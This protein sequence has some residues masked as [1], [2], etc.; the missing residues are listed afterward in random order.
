MPWMRTGF[1]VVEAR[2]PVLSSTSRKLIV[3]PGL[4]TNQF[5][6][7][8]M[9]FDPEKDIVPLG[10]VA[11]IPNLLIVKNT[12]PFK[13]VAELIAY[14]KANPGKLNYGSSG[15]GATP[16]L[17]GEL[18]KRMAG[19]DI[20]VVHYRGGAPAMNDLLSG[21]IDMIFSNI[22]DAIGQVRGGA[23]RA[24]GISTLKRST[25]EPEFPTIADTVPGYDTTSWIGV[26]A[27]AGTP[28]AIC[29][30]IEAGTRAICQDPILKARLADLVSEPVGSSAAEFTA[31]VAAER[32]QWGKLIGDLK[33]R[34]E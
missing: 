11:S 28:M 13:S 30:A 19:V 8:R 31:Y 16:H 22:P 14:A 6:Y 34:G 2:F 23:V 29:D 1:V 17:S 5:L 24:L 26:G 15:I 21:H 12:L 32:A 20:V 3:P 9:S 10:Q 33:I 25:I 7:A 18:F 4:A 27:R